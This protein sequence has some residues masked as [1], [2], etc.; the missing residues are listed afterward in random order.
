MPSDDE[1]DDE[2]SSPDMGMVLS[3]LYSLTKTVTKFERSHK[4][5]LQELKIQM[6]KQCNSLAKPEV[7]S[8][9][10]SMKPTMHAATIDNVFI[11]L[12]GSFF[13]AAGAFFDKAV[14]EA[15]YAAICDIR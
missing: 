10:L 5:D 2:S 6:E 7:E 15:K 13:F 11:A 12:R 4:G 14:G 8:I 9:N 1:S 3:T